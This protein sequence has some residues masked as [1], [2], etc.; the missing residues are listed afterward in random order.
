MKNKTKE[1]LM[2]IIDHL[3]KE[4]DTL[5]DENLSLW[6]MMEEMKKGGKLVE[7]YLVIPLKINF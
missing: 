3:L 1:E 5:K 6:D 2:V 4:I 7:T